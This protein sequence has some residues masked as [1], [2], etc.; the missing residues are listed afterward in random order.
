MGTKKQHKSAD[1][2]RMQADSL[3]KGDPGSWMS[4]NGN[5]LQT[6]RPIRAGVSDEVAQEFQVTSSGNAN[7]EGPQVNFQNEISDP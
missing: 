3:K 1:D 6:A 2:D 7:V 5:G 4:E